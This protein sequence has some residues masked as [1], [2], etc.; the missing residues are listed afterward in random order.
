MTGPSPHLR[1]YVHGRLC[2]R[3]SDRAFWWRPRF[4]SN[5][6]EHE[7]SSDIQI[8]VSPQVGVLPAR[9]DTR[10]CILLKLRSRSSSHV[11]DV[12]EQAMKTPDLREQRLSAC[13]AHFGPRCCVASATG[14]GQT[15]PRAAGPPIQTGRIRAAAGCPQTG[16]GHR[17]PRRVGSA[18]WTTVPGARPVSGVLGSAGHFRL[19]YGMPALP[20]CGPAEQGHGAGDGR[21]AQGERI[22]H[23]VGS[24]ASNRLRRAA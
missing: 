20:P 24:S 16:G 13:W 18:G 5:S 15:L 11:L 7:G 8:R 12:E 3:R 10:W 14:A 22:E 19:A 9:G 21:H 1:T 17:L 2:P 23:R 6:G 4:G